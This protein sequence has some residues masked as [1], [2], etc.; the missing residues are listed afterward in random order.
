MQRKYSNFYTWKDMKRVKD[1][2]WKKNLTSGWPTVDHPVTSKEVNGT[3][4]NHSCR[5]KWY[6]PEKGTIWCAR[7]KHNVT[8]NNNTSDL[9]FPQRK[10]E[11]ERM[12]YAP[13]ENLKCSGH[14]T[15]NTI[16]KTYKNCP[17]QKSLIKTFL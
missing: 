10:V 11:K 3:M 5:E 14:G 6:L 15:Q 8:P 17:N 16:T 1:W 2:K 9:S 12:I 4:M 13:P 7:K